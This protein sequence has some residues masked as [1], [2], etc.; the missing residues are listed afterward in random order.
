MIKVGAILDGIKTM[1][2]GTLKLAFAL[3][4]VNKEVGAEIITMHREFGWLLF[5]PTPEISAPEEPPVELD[6][7]KTPGQRLRSVL[8]ILWEQTGKN[9][10]FETFYR[11]KMEMIIG[12]VKD[13]LEDK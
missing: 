7:K 12:W 11:K 9:D 1:S 10:D 13:K 3:N 2:D 4:E 8:Y 5:S 6:V